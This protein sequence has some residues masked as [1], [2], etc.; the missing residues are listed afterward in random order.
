MAEEKEKDYFWQIIAAVVVAVA[1]GVFMVKKSEQDKY[2]T[3]ER[4][5]QE[6]PAMSSYR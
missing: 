6:D 2:K 5:I 1:V 3:A 4:A